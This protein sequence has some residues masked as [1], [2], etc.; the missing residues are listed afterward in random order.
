MHRLIHL[1][2]ISRNLYV[3]PMSKPHLHPAQLCNNILSWDTPVLF[4]I[5][6]LHMRRLPWSAFISNSIFLKALFCFYKILNGVSISLWF[7]FTLCGVY[8]N[9]KDNSPHAF[10]A[11]KPDYSCPLSLYFDLYK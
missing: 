7:N 1:T 6:L 2:D 3:D 9:G 8:T 5:L 11:S 4:I 10:Y